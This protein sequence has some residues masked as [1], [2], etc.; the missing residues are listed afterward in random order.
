M[1]QISIFAG[2]GYIIFDPSESV[3]QINQTPDNHPVPYLAS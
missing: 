1:S 2:I 3:K